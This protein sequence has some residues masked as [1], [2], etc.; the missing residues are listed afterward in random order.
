MESLRRLANSPTWQR[1]ASAITSPLRMGGWFLL[2]NLL[3]IAGMVGVYGACTAGAYNVGNPSARAFADLG[4]GKML[5]MAIFLA[6]TAFLTFFVPIRVFGTFL[7]PR[8]GRYFDQIVLSGVSP[9]RYLIGKLWAQNVFLLVVLAVSMPYFLLCLSFGGISLGYVVVC[10]GNLVLYV[11]LLVIAMLAASMFVSE[12]VA[13][14]GVITLFAATGFVGALP[15][16]PHPLNLTP[17]ASMVAPLYQSL[18]DWHPHFEMK[19]SRTFR[20]AFHGLTLFQSHWMLYMIEAVCLLLMG[21]LA[22]ALGPLNCLAQGLNTFGEA[23]FKGDKKRPS[24]V[25]KRYNVRRQA[26]L[27]FLYENTSRVWRERDFARRWMLREILFVGL[28]GTALIWL[29]WLIADRAYDQFYPMHLFFFLCTLLLNI[30]LFSETWVSDRLR[31][32]KVEAGTLNVWYFLANSVLIFLA[33]GWL[34]YVLEFDPDPYW[35]PD[36]DPLSPYGG[37]AAFEQNVRLMGLLIVV[38]WSAYAIMRYQS[39]CVASKVGMAGATLLFTQILWY[40]PLWLAYFANAS[41]QDAYEP[42]RAVWLSMCS[43]FAS[44]ELLLGADVDDYENLASARLGV[45][46]CAVLHLIISGVLFVLYRRRRKRQLEAR[47]L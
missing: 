25:R 22:V 15:W 5:A 39:L 43:P 2:L 10:F 42:E 24:W 26:E 47:D 21:G 18:L 20:G 29:Y 35:I 7:G 28:M 46:L 44:Y 19:T 13:L 4:L 33:F 12:I 23:I 32:G 40:A 27:A 8:V 38:S 17:S 11:N 14:I 1:D 45:K 34:P 3:I 6:L 16:G 37:L 36:R 41:V 9:W 31:C 30:L